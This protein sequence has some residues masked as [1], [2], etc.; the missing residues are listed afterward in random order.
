MSLENF[1]TGLVIGFFILSLYTNLT[2]L[3]EDVMTY[4][5]MIYFIFLFFLFVYILY[6]WDG[7][8]MIKFIIG[9]LSL[10]NSI[11]FFACGYGAK[12]S[13]EKRNESRLLCIINNCYDN[14]CK[15]F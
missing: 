10:F 4:G 5:Y 14:I 2:N 7:D 11:V 1:I 12:E 15:S 8:Y 3:N 6:K 13:D 9:S